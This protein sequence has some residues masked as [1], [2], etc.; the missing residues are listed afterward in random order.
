MTSLSPVSW[1]GREGGIV[2]APLWGRGVYCADPVKALVL[3]WTL[4]QLQDNHADFHLTVLG[5]QSL[6]GGR[7]VE[8]ADILLRDCTDCPPTLP[9]RASLFHAASAAEMG[10]FWKEVGFGEAQLCFVS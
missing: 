2:T 4:M 9:V 1:G 7:G 6:S 5:G 10:R 3:A 8:G